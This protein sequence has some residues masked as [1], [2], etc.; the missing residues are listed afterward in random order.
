M[1]E[2][3]KYINPFTDFGFKKL[4]GTEFNKELLIDF[5]NQ[6]LGDR[7]QVRD[8]TYQNTEH[9]GRTETDRKAVFDLFCENERGEK[10]IIEIQNV[11]QQFF[12]DRSIFYATFPLREQSEKGRNWDYSL[13][14]VYT[15]GILNFSF[16]DAAGRDRYVREIQLLD[17]ETFEVFYDK[18]TFIYLEMPRFKKREEELLT[19][20]DKWM[21]VLKHLPR[22]QEKPQWL[23]EKVFEKLF[24]EAELA[25]LTPEDMN[26]YE[27]SLKVYRDNKNAM[28]YAVKIA[29]EAAKREGRLEERI[30]LAR[31]MKTKHMPVEQIMELT[32]FTRAEIEKL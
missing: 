28:D 25:K 29:A 1:P 10:F 32:G 6:V 3:E 16:P 8:L 13:K 26:R 17:K 5:L 23:Q 22:L 30:E 2:Q 18:L 15:I 12:K 7:E 27:E 11:A 20:F 14:A 19:H 4:F 9:Q 21:Y 24:S 31:K